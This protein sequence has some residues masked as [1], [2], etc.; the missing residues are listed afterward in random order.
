ME[1]RDLP[2]LRGLQVLLDFTEPAH[3]L[4]ALGDLLLQTR[5]TEN[6]AQPEGADAPEST[7]VARLA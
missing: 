5:R 2:V 6:G 3:L 1:Q 7:A 4:S